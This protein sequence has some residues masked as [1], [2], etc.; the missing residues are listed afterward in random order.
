M[1]NFNLSASIKSL[2]IIVVCSL[3]IFTSC[4]EPTI[5]GVE[6]PSED[7]FNFTKVDTFTVI[8]T[9]VKEDTIFTRNYMRGLVGHINDNIFG[10]ITN[11]AYV[12]FLPST[13][14]KDIG[15]SPIVDSVKLIL[16]VDKAGGGAYGNG[17]DNFLIK[18]NEI[19]TTVD[20][21]ST[22]KYNTN[23][24]LKTYNLNLTNGVFAPIVKYTDVLLSEKDSIKT[25]MNIRLEN[26]LGTKLI[27]SKKATE[28]AFLSFFKGLKI[29]AYP[30]NPNNYGGVLYFNIKDSRNKIRVYYHTTID[31]VI[32]NDSLYFDYVAN[33][34]LCT[35][36]NSVIK[37]YSII[38]PYYINQLNDSDQA[39][40]NF[41]TRGDSLL[42]LQG[43]GKSKIRIQFPYFKNF[44]KKGI[45]I[46]K[47][48]LIIPINTDFSTDAKLV[49]GVTTLTGF[50][51]QNVNFYLPDNSSPSDNYFGGIHLTKT[52]EY[53]F[54]ITRY[55]Q[56]IVNNP[57]KNFYGFYF[58]NVNT[59]TEPSRVILNGGNKKVGNRMRLEV[60]YTII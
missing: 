56:S 17:Y 19:D 49:P 58:F 8:A 54:N 12:Q 23:D 15:P 60:S 5:T 3:F 24:T 53:T 4:K 35:S 22:K 26:S 31:N 50:S 43:L 51:E 28:I 7:D 11:H 10:S 41:L 37:N 25:Y 6:T 48:K 46:H 57:S 34:N 59:P 32:L 18:I 16:F 45:V 47:A 2:A 55:L 44:I 21:S 42:F 27:N 1:K 20:F 9:T 36:F 13:L 38:N 40:N 30:Q 33:S 29:S 52:K 39:K 14:S